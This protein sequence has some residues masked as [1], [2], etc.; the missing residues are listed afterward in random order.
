MLLDKIMSD[1]DNGNNAAV[2]ATLVDWS[3]AFPRLDS[4]LGISSF[5]K[6]GVRAS[7]MPI[8]SSFFEDRRMCVKWQGELSSVR[9]MP[10]GGSQGSTFGVLGY[11]S[12]SNDNADCVPI[13]ERFKFMD[14]LTFLET[15]LLTNIG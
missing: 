8:I 2:I 14:E 9:P 13:E 5:I 7:L 1:F 4:T 3:K 6:N 11:L 10:A 15:L 12:Q